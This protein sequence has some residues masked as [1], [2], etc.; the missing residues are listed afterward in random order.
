M[1]QIIT[2]KDAITVVLACKTKN[3]RFK[4]YET[5]IQRI[6]FFG[7]IV[8]IVIGIIT[9]LC[10]RYMRLEWLGWL[11]LVCV[12]SSSVL[13]VA[14]Q[15]AQMVPEI[16]KLKNP[17]RETSN[18]LVEV[19]NTDMDLIH[20]L[21][22]SFEPQHLSYARAMYSNMAKHIRE[23]IGL[24]VGALDKIGIVPVAVTAYLSYAKAMK[25]GISFGPYEWIGISFVCLY[26]LAIRMTSTAQWMEH[27]A[28]LYAHAY[29]VRTSK[30]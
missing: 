20:Q 11:A 22:T 26:L 19:F 8:F 1:I 4:F 25:D 28:E 17:E 27:I 3:F 9:G 5:P 16:V 21:S 15:V 10:F 23:R 30:V 29:T 14:Y 7:S 18:S 6:T 13:A 12:A 24:L 2:P